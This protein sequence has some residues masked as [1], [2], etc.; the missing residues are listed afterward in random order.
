VDIPGGYTI[1]NPEEDTNFGRTHQAP[2]KPDEASSNQN[3]VRDDSYLIDF[4]RAH[5]FENIDTMPPVRYRNGMMWDDNQERR[6]DNII[7]MRWVLQ[8]EFASSVVFFHKVTIP[9]GAIEGTHRHIGTEEL[10]CIVEGEG[11]AY[12]GDGDDPS[13]SGYPLVERQI[14]GL[15]THVCREVPVKPGSVIFTKSGG[16]H[17]IKNPGDKPLRFVAFLYHTA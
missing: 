3:T 10:Y 8:R 9:P 7:E 11:I 13:A 15:G 12:L 14:Y 5:F 6:D 2:I 4:Q 16:I 1:N 17:G